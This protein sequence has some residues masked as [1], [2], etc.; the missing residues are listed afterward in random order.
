MAEDEV[1]HFNI[2]VDSIDIIEVIYII[3]IIDVIYIID[4]PM[5]TVQR[6]IYSLWYTS[7]DLQM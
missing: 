5:L 2:V 6:R 3:Y 4:N 7:T 1:I